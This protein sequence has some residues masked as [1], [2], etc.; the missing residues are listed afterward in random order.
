MDSNFKHYD[1]ANDPNEGCGEIKIFE[2]EKHCEIKYIKVAEIKF[3][4]KIIF[5]YVCNMSMHIGKQANIQNVTHD[6]NLYLHAKM[7]STN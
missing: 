1:P 6:R 2:R 7:K 3:N 5:I 4:P